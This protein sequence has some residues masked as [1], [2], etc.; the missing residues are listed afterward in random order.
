VVE[1][2]AGGRRQEAGGRK[3]V[4]VAD[5]VR[6]VISLISLQSVLEATEIMRAV[7]VPI[8]GASTVGPRVMYLLVD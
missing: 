6:V 5:E 8:R 4:G 3:Q 2:G 7:R 1:G